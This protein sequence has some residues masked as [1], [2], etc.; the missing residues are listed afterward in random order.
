MHGSWYHTGDFSEGIGWTLAA[1][2]DVLNI[3]T[4]ECV[5][6]LAYRVSGR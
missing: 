1:N 5:G 4:K 2:L 3:A 6:S